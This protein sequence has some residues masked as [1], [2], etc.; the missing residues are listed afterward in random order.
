MKNKEVLMRYVDNDGVVNPD[1]EEV[2]EI[3]EIWQVNIV[4]VIFK[5][6]L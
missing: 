2:K 1:S 3:M 6:W 5:K 4:Q